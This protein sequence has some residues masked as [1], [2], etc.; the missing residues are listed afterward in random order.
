LE[1]NNL[2]V[3]LVVD[4][5]VYSN[6]SYVLKGFQTIRKATMQ[7]HETLKTQATWGYEVI[8]L[9]NQLLPN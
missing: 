8:K 6:S 2:N 3:D 9:A 7:D 1:K 5:Q 4:S